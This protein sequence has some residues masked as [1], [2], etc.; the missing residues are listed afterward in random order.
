MLD[1]AVV[2]Y[3]GGVHERGILAPSSTNAAP[4]LAAGRHD[5]RIYM[6]KHASS[7]SHLVAGLV[8]GASLLGATGIVLAAVAAGD[9]TTWPQYRIAVGAHSATVVSGTTGTKP[10]AGFTTISQRGFRLAFDASAE[11]VL[12]NPT[13]P[14]DQ[15]DWNKLPGLS[16]CGS[17]DL[18]QNGFMFGWRW[19]TDLTPRVL[20]VTAYW[21]RAG[22]HLN[23]P[24]P[25]VVLSA[26]EVESGVPLT[27]SEKIVGSTYEFRITGVIGGR[28][29]DATATGTRNCSGSTTGLKWASGLY[30]GGTSTAPQVITARVTEP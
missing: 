8:V 10:K 23:A 14:A 12:T 29:I 13:Q 9:V 22:V 1:E 30:F 16:D 2:V 15:F 20:E 6:S 21:N 25:M 7:H 5:E 4:A 17:L 18:S 3:P 11:Y 27:Y 24:E 28:S 26:A 19:R